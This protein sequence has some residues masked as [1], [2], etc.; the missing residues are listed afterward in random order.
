MQSTG[1]TSTTHLQPGA[2]S[3]LLLIMICLSWSSKQSS[4]HHSYLPTLTDWIPMSSLILTPLNSPEYLTGMDQQI[5]KS[6]QGLGKTLWFSNYFF[7]GGSALSTLS[8]G[9]AKLWPKGKLRPSAL[10]HV[11]RLEACPVVMWIYYS[12]SITHHSLSTG[13]TRLSLGVLNSVALDGLWVFWFKNQSSFTWNLLQTGSP[14]FALALGSSNFSI[15]G[16]QN[17]NVWPSLA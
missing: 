6:I 10:F 14:N 15:C 17:R 16:P 4:C 9:M 3:V 2:P 12:I 8:P 1:A 7:C 11:A 13:V 5:T